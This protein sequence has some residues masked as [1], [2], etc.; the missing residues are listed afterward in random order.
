MY[1]Y[2]KVY[3]YA[4]NILNI[5]VIRSKDRKFYEI[6]VVLFIVCN[7]LIKGRIIVDEQTYFTRI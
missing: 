6:L 4:F 7:F 5:Y 2:M 1:V 3:N